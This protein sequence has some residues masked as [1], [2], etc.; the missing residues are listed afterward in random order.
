MKTTHFIY[1]WKS[2]EKYYLSVRTATNPKNSVLNAS[3]F[4]AWGRNEMA[5]KLHKKYTRSKIV[6]SVN[7]NKIK[8]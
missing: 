5:N 6:R 4:S 3:Y 1:C 8:K 2:G 7:P